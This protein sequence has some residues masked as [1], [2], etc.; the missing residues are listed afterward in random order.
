M[1]EYEALGHMTRLDKQVSETDRSYYLS[2]HA[3]CR[4]SSTTTKLRVVFGGS[5]KTTTNISLNDAQWVG[6]TVQSDLFS[7][8]LRF[9]KQK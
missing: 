2:H 8:L 6:P 7:I 1:T 5:T 9:R 4:E 3:V